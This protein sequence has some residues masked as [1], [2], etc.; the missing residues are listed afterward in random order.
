MVAVQQRLSSVLTVDGTYVAEGRSPFAECLA[1]G[2]SSFSMVSYFGTCSSKDSFNGKLKG[3]VE[4][5]TVCDV[6]GVS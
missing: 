4:G 6:K 1:E 5:Y 2:L 3:N